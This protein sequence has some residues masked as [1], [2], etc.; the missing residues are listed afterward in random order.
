MRKFKAAAAAMLIGLGA[1]PA[2]AQTKPP[3]GEVRE[4]HDG[5][6]A[7]GLADEIRKR[8][9]NIGARMITA[10]TTLNA[11]KNR[12]RALG[13]SDE[14]IED[15]VTSKA[16]KKQMRADGEAYMAARGVSP[17]DTAGLCRVGL[18]EIARGSAIGRLLREK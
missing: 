16:E 11:L 18:D 3:L 15:Y 9:D 12:A 14:E 7:V 5:L 8:C 13:Y 6:L 4:I 1:L 2:A 10:M 17:K